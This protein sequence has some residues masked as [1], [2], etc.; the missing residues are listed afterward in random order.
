MMKHNRMATLLMVGSLLAAAPP[1]FAQGKGQDHGK[2]HG[3]QAKGNKQERG[4]SNQAGPQ[5]D[6][7][8]KANAVARSQGNDKNDRSSQ[9]IKTVA[10]S[11][12][13]ASVSSRG[14]AKRFKHV[15]R[16]T[17]MKPELRR[18]AVSKRAPE[19]I[20]AGAMSRG[21]ARGLRA[22]DV[23]IRQNGDKV[24]LFNRSGIML[25]DLDET[26]ARN[27]GGWRVSPYDD[28]VKSGAPSFCR[29]GEGHPVLGRE[30]CL[31]KGFGLGD[32]RDL[33]WGRTTD[34]GDI[35]FRRQADSGTLARSVLLG[36]LGDVVFNRLGLHALTLGYNDPLTGSWYGEPNGP[37]ML[38]V[39]SGAIPI[40]EIYD[41][42]RDD[43][44]DVLV[45]ALRPW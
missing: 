14:S 38:R 32:Y 9:T 41:A 15:V 7:K 40:A 8:G 19:R 20:M 17:D 16:V 37:R 33:R 27:L 11:D 25:L 12:D 1:L 31:D 23:V 10:R 36:V 45:V 5:K 34:V 13:R 6:N 42:D 21:H 39:T 3:Q 28:D 44:A 43:R 4:K 2:E 30:W 24:V 18:Y 26:R 35:S 29:S 22:D